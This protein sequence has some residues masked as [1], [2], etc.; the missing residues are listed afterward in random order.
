MTTRTRLSLRSGLALLFALTAPLTALGQT[1]SDRAAW[2]CDGSIC[3]QR[4]EVRLGQL[5]GSFEYGANVSASR[6]A[7]RIKVLEAQQYQAY[8]F[9][10]PSP[11]K[12]YA[13][14][15]R[16]EN[17]IPSDW[18]RDIGIQSGGPGV[19]LYR[20][21]D[22]NSWE[23]ISQGDLSPAGAYLRVVVV[24]SRAGSTAYRTFYP[25]RWW[26]DISYRKVRPDDG[27]TDAGPDLPG[28]APIGGAGDHFTP[29]LP[30]PAADP[31]DGTQAECGPG[32]ECLPD[33]GQVAV[34]VADDTPVTAKPDPRDGGALARMVQRELLRVD[35]YDLEVDGIWG[36][37]SIRAMTNYNRW[38]GSSW[39]VDHASADALEELLGAR[40]PVCGVD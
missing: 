31:A 30:D 24:Q 14:S 23:K 1:D 20:S 32:M 15:Y 22:G 35:C 36:P 18:P 11:M 7:A 17:W 28:P 19:D 12:I 29:V 27:W 8:D 38:F 33:G 21:I 40:A 39:P 37:G 13:R 9:N 10:V 3:V 4:E 16:D 6:D 2:D 34:P 5:H 25:A 26:V